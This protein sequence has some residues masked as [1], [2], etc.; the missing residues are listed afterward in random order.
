MRA[1]ELKA[2]LMA[3]AE[4]S[5]DKIIAEKSEAHEIGLREIET[6][7]IQAGQ[8]FRESVLKEL[9]EEASRLSSAQAFQCPQC[10]KRLHE[11]G[12]RAKRI[13]SAAG[14][15]TVRRAYAYCPNCHTGFFPLG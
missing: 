14:E 13:V 2:N 4:S 6:T 15:V 11:K 10:H 5:I 9:V 7:A 12:L 1:E 8:A 3:Q